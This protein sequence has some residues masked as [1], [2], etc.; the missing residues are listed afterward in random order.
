[1]GG[2][3][4]GDEVMEKLGIA[5]RRGCSCQFQHQKRRKSKKKYEKTS[6]LRENEEA[7][8]GL[9]REDRFV[10]NVLRACNVQQGASVAQ[11]PMP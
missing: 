1:M 11:T 6:N 4:A 10:Q 9:K 2:V 8:A 7:C 5:A 3:T